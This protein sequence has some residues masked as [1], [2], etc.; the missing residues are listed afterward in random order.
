MSVQSIE[1]EPRVLA[2]GG[3]ASLVARMIAIGRAVARGVADEVMYMLRED[4]RH[5]RI[6][7]DPEDWER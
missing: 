5:G 4:L 1:H 2:T 3:Y 7:R 6:S